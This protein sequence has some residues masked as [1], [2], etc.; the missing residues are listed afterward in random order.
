MQIYIFSLL[1]IFCGI[2]VMGVRSQSHIISFPFILYFFLRYIL[3]LNFSMINSTFVSCM[4]HDL[5]LW[6]HIAVQIN[7]DRDFRFYKYNFL[8]SVFSL[9]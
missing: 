9:T 7:F 6:L 4:L 2:T 5:I 1:S 3:I 8:L